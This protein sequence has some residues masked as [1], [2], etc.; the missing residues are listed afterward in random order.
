MSEFME[1][2]TPGMIIVGIILLLSIVLIFKILKSLGK[3]I[4]LLSV[5]AIISFSIYKFAPGVIA[6][7][8]DFVNGGWMESG[9]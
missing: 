2:I 4:I 9:K 6:P 3:G 1:S 8:K 5:L 7:L